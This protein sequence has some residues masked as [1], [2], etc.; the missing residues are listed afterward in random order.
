[1]GKIHIFKNIYSEEVFL[2]N[3]DNDFYITLFQQI[4]IRKRF[5]TPLSV[6]FLFYCSIYKNLSLF[7]CWKLRFHISP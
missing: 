2:S 7:R 6:I 3:I 1:M 4:L 5:E